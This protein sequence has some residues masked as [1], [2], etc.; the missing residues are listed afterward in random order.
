VNPIAS[1]AASVRG[2][3]LQQ[4]LSNALEPLIEEA[5]R[6]QQLPAPTFAEEQR[7]RY[8]QQQ[9]QASGLADV[10]IDALFN[11]YG[12]LPG[13]AL[14]APALLVSAHTDTVFPADT[15]LTATRDALK[16][17]APGIGDNSL[18]VAALLCL[19][20]LLRPLALHTDVWF[21][22]NTREEGLGD[23]GGIRA[24]VDRLHAQI[25][26]CIVLEGMAYG[27]IYHAGIAVRRLR[28]STQA[29]GG[30]SWL[31]YGQP[32]AIHSLVRFA[33]KLTELAPPQQPRTTYN[34]G[35]IEGGRSVNSIATEANLTLDMRSE[36]SGALAA[37]EAN[38]MHALEVCQAADKD[39]QFKVEVVGDRPAGSL[40]ISHPLV[41][42]AKDALEVTKMQP[43]FHM[44]STDANLP[45][46]RG[47]P[48]VTIGITTGGNAHRTDE[49]IDLAPIPRGMW[50]LIL[51]ALS[52]SDSL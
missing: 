8:V 32:S 39:V 52:A 26:A 34:I 19:M 45:L 2:V 24:A 50:Q 14:A 42:A 7:A 28:I 18:G 49:Y 51:L 27:Q 11:V 46:A 35:L 5:I 17:N 12:R 33:A 16:I 43:V 20:R 23:L 47:I 25:G 3:D 15:D 6:I 31:H 10:S 21:V 13:R 4:R 44:G 38:V 48:A 41:R 1:F 37:L 29:A 9:F 36:D 30:H 40:P 22:A